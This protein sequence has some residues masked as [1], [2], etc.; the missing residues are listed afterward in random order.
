MSSKKKK[1]PSGMFDFGNVL[2]KFED[3]KRNLDAIRERLKAVNEIDLGRLLSDVC[4]LME[5]EA[6]QLLASKL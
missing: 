6:L 1:R 4:V 5:D 3:E 2:S